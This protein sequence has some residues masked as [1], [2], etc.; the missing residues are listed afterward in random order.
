MAISVNF[1]YSHDLKVCDHAT[2]KNIFTPSSRRATLKICSHSLLSLHKADVPQIWSR[3]QSSHLYYRRS[4]PPP[5][6]LP[7]Q[8]QQDPVT[9]PEL[10][11]LP[12]SVVFYAAMTGASIAL[13]KNYNVLSQLQ[14][15]LQLQASLPYL[16]VMLG[17]LV[18][19]TALAEVLPSFKELKEL[20]QR[21][22]IPQLKV[23][24]LWGL[25]AM[26]IG[27]GVGE[28]AF[29]RG[30]LQSWIVQQA[31]GIAGTSPEMATAAGVF[32]A[33]IIFG[34]AHSVTQSY[35][36]FATAAGAVFGLEYLNCGLLA[37][38]FT[39]ALYDFI[40]FVA[41]INYWGGNSGSGSNPPAPPP[42]P[43]SKID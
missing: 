19:S 34:A 22:L 39:H 14:A 20:Y 29:F 23:L 25:A 7:P 10:P 30:V 32:A 26:S 16:G 6:A 8:Q 12:T 36:I 31:G 13:G 41:I 17:F 28:E 37:A 40:A 15:P 5:H 24:P 3:H 43:P 33:S 35:F 42:P 9:P 4:L 11:I 38:A 2:H 1:A 21:T 27:A 18:V